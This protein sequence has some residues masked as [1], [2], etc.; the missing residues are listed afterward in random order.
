MYSEIEYSIDITRCKPEQFCV[1][2][3]GQSDHRKQQ[4]TTD[5]YTTDITCD[6][7]ASKNLTATRHH[8]HHRYPA[9]QSSS[10]S[11]RTEQRF[12]HVHCLLKRCML[13]VNS[14]FLIQCQRIE[15]TDIV[16]KPAGSVNIDLNVFQSTH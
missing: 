4:Y 15:L 10:F 14:M 12:R 13:S 7:T 6:N 8:Y 5:K 2:A 1:Q 11:I 3:T 16:R 9:Q